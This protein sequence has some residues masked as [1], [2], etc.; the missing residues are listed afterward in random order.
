MGVSTFRVNVGFPLQ[1]VVDHDSKNLDLRPE[2]CLGTTSPGMTEPACLLFPI[3]SGLLE[4]NQ[5]VF[6]WREHD[7][8]GA[9]PVHNHFVCPRQHCAIELIPTSPRQPT[10]TCHRHIQTQDGGRA[11]LKFN[12]FETGGG[13]EQEKSGRHG[14]PLGDASRTQNALVTPPGI[15]MTMRREERKEWMKWSI[16]LGMPL[17]ARI[18]SSSTQSTLS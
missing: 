16:H 6:L 3:V 9:G 2:T 12:A 13:E 17:L 4:M 14:T 8:S 7:A 10:G 1:S 15:L 18:L 5:L 11:V